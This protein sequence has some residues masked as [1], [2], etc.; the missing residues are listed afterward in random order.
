MTRAPSARVATGVIGAIDASVRARR[1]LT[2]ATGATATGF[3][4]DGRRITGISVRVGG[5][6]KQFSQLPL[7]PSVKATLDHYRRW[8][9]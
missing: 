2:I 5:E 3:V 4:F 6:D 1:N 8:A 9:P 7:L